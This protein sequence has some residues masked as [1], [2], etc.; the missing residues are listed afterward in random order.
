MGIEQQLE[1]ELRLG[2]ELLAEAEVELL[3]Q[4]AT[5]EDLR[6]TVDRLRGAVRVL[7]GE[8]PPQFEAEEPKVEVATPQAVPAKPAQADDLDLDMSP[9]EWAA[10]RERK[11]RQR[12]KELQA[13]NAGPYAQVACTGCG[14]KGTLQEVVM[15][16]PGGMPVKML[17]CSSC[18]NQ[19]LT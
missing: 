2:E 11:R 14:T 5:T 1:A 9:E 13:E 10:D 8:P 19:L 6:Q 4:T 12:E 3:K 15:Q 18:G 17:T 16:S 7:N